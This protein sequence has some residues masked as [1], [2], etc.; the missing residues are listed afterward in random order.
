MQVER[1]KGS[2]RISP[3]K[4]NGKDDL[5]TSTTLSHFE[6]QIL[7]RTAEKRKVAL[8]KRLTILL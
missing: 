1:G 8:Q 6:T 5:H 3:E 4:Q 7:A 2:R